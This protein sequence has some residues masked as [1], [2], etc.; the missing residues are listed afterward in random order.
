MTPSAA[1]AGASVFQLVTGT[2]MRDDSLD[3]SDDN[4]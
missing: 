2:P 1:S 3:A 4:R